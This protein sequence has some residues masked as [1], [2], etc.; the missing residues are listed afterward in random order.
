MVAT[1]EVLAE[2][3]SAG[4]S[5]GEKIG[6]VE[7]TIGISD[8]RPNPRTSRESRVEALAEWLFVTWQLQN[9]EGN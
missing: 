6:K 2:K 5:T 9:R 3:I 4:E 1:D 8:S 7:F